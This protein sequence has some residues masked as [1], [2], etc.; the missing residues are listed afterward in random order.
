MTPERWRQVEEIFY[1]ALECEPDRRA[2]FLDQACAGDMELRKEVES[3]LAHDEEAE[4]KSFLNFNTDLVETRVQT[5]DKRPDPVTDRREPVRSDAFETRTPQS[6]PSILLRL[7]SAVILTLLLLLGGVWLW[8]EWSD[9]ERVE[10][11]SSKAGQ[12]PPEEQVYTHTAQSLNLTF[13]HLSISQG[14]SS[15]SVYCI[16]QDRHGFMWFGTQDG[17]NRYDGY[18]FKVFRHNPQ[19]KNT[20]SDNYIADIFEDSAGSLWIGTADGGLN[21]YDPESESFIRYRY[22]DK[23]PNSINSNHIITLKEDRT[24]ALW[25]GTSSGLSRLDQKNGKFTSYSYDPDN[26]NSLSSNHTTSIYQ[27]RE[28]ILWVGTNGGGLNRFDPESQSFISYKHDPN[29]PS[30]L[31]N[32]HVTSIIQDES[33]TLWIGAIDGALNR[34]TPESRTFVAYRNEDKSDSIFSIY[35]DRA[36]IL[37]LGTAAG[38]GRFDPLDHSYARYIHDDKDPESIS[39]NRIQAVYKDRSGALWLGMIDGGINRCDPNSRKFIPRRKDNNNP[40][41]LSSSNTTAIYQD[42]SGTV[43]VGTADRGLNRYDAQSQSYTTYRYDPADQDSLRSDHVTAISEDSSGR[44]LIGSSGGLN[45]YDPQKRVLIA[46]SDKTNPL[47]GLE[48]SVTTIRKDRSGKIWIGTRGRGLYRYDPES[49]DLTSYNDD[50]GPPTGPNSRRIS[51]ILE[52]RS[53]TIWI[54]TI[55]SGL[56]RYD[57]ASQT[58]T[59]YKNDPYSSTSISNNRINTICEDRS[60]TLWIGTPQG[61]NR[62]NPKDETFTLFLKQEGFPNDNIY[63]ILEDND[64]NLWLSTNQGLTKFDPKTKRFRNY[65]VSDGLQS[66]EFNWG[67]Y[68]KSS[69]GELFFGGINGLNSFYPE[70]IK[71]NGYIPPVVITSFKAFDNAG[72]LVLSRESLESQIAPMKLIYK[73]NYLLFEFAALNYTHPEKNRYAYK[74]E[75][76]DKEWIESNA[77]RMVRY[78]NLA[79][80]EYVFRVIGSNNDG[81][82]NREGATVRFIITPPLWKTWWAYLLYF[83]GLTAG[84]YSGHRY[85]LHI[86]EKRNEILEARVVDRTVEVNRKKEEL[87]KKNEEL[88]KK[89][90]ELIESNRRADRIF[91]ALAEALPGTVLDGKYRLDDKIGAGGFG[92]VYRATHLAL[93]QAVAV[94]VFKPSPGNDSAVELERFKLEAISACRVNHPNAVAVLDSGISAEGIAYLVMELLDGHTL[95]SEMRE[96]KVLSIERCAQ[97]LLPVCDALSKAHS[98]GIIHRDI[99]PENIFLHKTEDGEVVKVVD[100]GIAKFIEQGPDGGI[101]DLTATGGLIGTPLYIAPERLAMTPYDGRADVY[102]LGMV[103]YEMLCGRAPFLLGN[104][105][106]AGVMMAHLSQEPPRL[107]EFN[108]LI[109]REIEDV[110]MRT[111]EKDPQKRPTAKELAREFAN[112]VVN[113]PVEVRD[114]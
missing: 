103:L 15:S 96:K 66:N 14:L 30:S 90:E 99:K 114:V 88:V 57:P 87:E 3:L 52:D 83:M 43:W 109:P 2:A 89:N 40:K 65:D 91:S 55:G 76:I 46:G 27:D 80:G 42:R 49:R 32:N 68:F 7:A 93:K 25:I 58:F 10:E 113:R 70:Q 37:W 20:I 75:G 85:R 50:P 9:V 105:G 51:N 71:D 97:I 39:D 22:N 98:V 74:L 79:P 112:A 36:G 24:G 100:F 56:N 44:L 63:G 108:P 12:N 11:Q 6:Q 29:N 54:G 47:F 26:P 95:G 4:G 67:S 111:L 41:S 106:F 53:G 101:N 35:K 78:S 62:Y 60:G 104:R 72:K 59:V 5:T 1:S 45:I 94:K 61:L 13:E 82:W 33:G 77:Q 18:T 34:F 73:N 107:R 16:L 21:R 84:I 92:A 69:K 86:V 17:L 48:V 28:G 110:V 19:D 31:S 8:N 23:D 64:G 102:S 38:L 81:V